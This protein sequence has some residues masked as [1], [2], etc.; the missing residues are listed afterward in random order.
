[1]KQTIRLMP[2]Y[3][4]WPLW[5]MNGDGDIDPHTLP[6]TSETV[7]RLIYWSDTF[8][9]SLNRDDPASSAWPNKET[10]EAFE[11]EGYQLWLILR[12]EL[13]HTYIVFYQDGAIVYTDPSQHP[14]H[15]S[16]SL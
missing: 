3:G 1:M 7:E 2:D 9:A 14:C 13:V 8:D 5:W 16:Q 12:Q 11:N 6:L 4:C 15:D 10:Y